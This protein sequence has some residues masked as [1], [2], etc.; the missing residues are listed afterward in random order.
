MTTEQADALSHLRLIFN[1][2]TGCCLAEPLWFPEDVQEVLVSV[3][4]GS[5]WEYQ[6]GFKEQG[7]SDSLTIVSLK[8]GEFGLMEEAEDY[9]GHGC[10][11]HSYTGRYNTLDELMRFGVEER[12][13]ARPLILQLLGERY[14]TGTGTEDA[15]RGSGITGT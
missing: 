11:C 6:E 7:D 14:G 2:I 15:R 13:G 10:C 5:G 9:T 8:D 12:H 1:T 3:W 4:S